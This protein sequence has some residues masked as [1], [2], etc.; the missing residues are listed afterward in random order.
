MSQVTRTRLAQQDLE[1]ILDYLDRHGDETA[2]RFAG[3]F[4]DTCELYAN[5]P[6]MGSNASEYA[7]NLRCFTVWNY[8]IFYRPFDGG[9]IEIIRIIHGARDIPKLFEQV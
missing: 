2:E 6:R 1:D 8:A 3:K 4:D 7:A 9:G 5:N